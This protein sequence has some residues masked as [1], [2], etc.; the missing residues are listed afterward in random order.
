MKY[1][2]ISLSFALLACTPLPTI[3][4]TPVAEAAILADRIADPEPEPVAEAVA[5]ATEYKRYIEGRDGLYKRSLLDILL[6]RSAPHEAELADRSADPEP[7]P[8]AEAGKAVPTI[9]SRQLEDLL[10]DVEE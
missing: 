6:G 2:S 4:A 3:L 9:T 8:V 1:L 5:A 7:D 10:N